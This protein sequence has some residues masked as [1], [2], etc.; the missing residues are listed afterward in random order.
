MSLQAFRELISEHKL[1]IQVIKAVRRELDE[2][3]RYARE[4]ED[5]ITARK[6]AEELLPGNW[7]CYEHVNTSADIKALN[8]V[9]IPLIEALRQERS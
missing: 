6:P 2:E 7:G 5:R 4:K 8:K 1:S 3:L 9:G